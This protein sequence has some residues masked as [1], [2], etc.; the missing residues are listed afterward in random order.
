MNEVNFVK[1]VD[2][3]SATN[4]HVLAE[5]ARTEKHLFMA[6][7]CTVKH[8]GYVLVDFGAEICGRLHVVFGYNERE[9][10]VRIR[11]GESVAEA[12][13]ELGQNN[14]GNYHS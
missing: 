2:S 7:T 12:C 9:G 8:G 4:T 13:A 5:N 1:I 3:K 10:N 11:L 14:A 6:Q